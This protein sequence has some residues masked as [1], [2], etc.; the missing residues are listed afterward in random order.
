M[1][2]KFSS[3]KPILLPLTLEKTKDET[4]ATEFAFWLASTFKRPLR[5]IHIIP[6]L[7]FLPMVPSLRLMV[8]NVTQ[9]ILEGN[10]RIK[11]ALQSFTANSL[12][13]DVSVSVQTYYG[14]PAKWISAESASSSFTVMTSQKPKYGFLRKLAT[15]Y[16]V[17][18]TCHGPVAVVPSDAPF[19][20]P[21]KNL[22]VLFADDLEDHTTE[23]ADFAGWFSSRF[24]QSDLCHVHV[25]SITPDILER[26]LQFALAGSQNS[27]ET[28][29]SVNTLHEKMLEDLKDTMSGRFAKWAHELDLSGTIYKPYL[30]QGHPGEHLSSIRKKINPDIEI[31]G[32]HQSYHG[33]AF[34]KVPFEAMMSAEY[35]VIIVPSK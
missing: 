5:A 30:L 1:Q 2:Y 26:S 9:E 16:K 25:T 33:N 8:P 28:Y 20:Y 3:L 35:P 22:R 31:F 17:L 6:N 18:A 11:D 23:A 34:G 13:S 27:G 24:K 29:P 10:K 19:S 15:V 21:A 7:E 12:Y 14:E 32:Q 4:R